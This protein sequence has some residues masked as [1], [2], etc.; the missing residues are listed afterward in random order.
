M[1]GGFLVQLRNHQV[2]FH[3]N[4]T[5]N[6]IWFIV[7]W[8]LHCC[9]GNAVSRRRLAKKWHVGVLDQEMNCELFVFLIKFVTH[10]IIDKLNNTK[11]LLNNIVSFSGKLIINDRT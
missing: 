2:T 3:I 4:I 8:D 9:H 11:K 10:K 5:Q 1:P 6:F 7:T